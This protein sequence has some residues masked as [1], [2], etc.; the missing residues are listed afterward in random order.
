M[1]LT[2]YEAIER[3]NADPQ[4]WEHVT[5]ESAHS[6]PVPIVRPDGIAL[7]FFWYPVGG[8][9]MNRFVVAPTWRTEISLVAPDQIRFAPVQPW[10]LGLDVEPK[11]QL[12]KPT[13]GGSIPTVEMKALRAEL[14]QLIDEI[15]QFYL[16]PHPELSE[17]EKEHARRFHAL[18]HRM[19]IVLLLPAY[20]SL[21]PD[22]FT[23]LDQI[24]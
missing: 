20:R 17:V 9:A 1:P 5:R 18:F 15:I 14:Y 22:F 12:G 21:N 23:W 13:I 6:L 8:P 24:V 2:T 19:A 10:E 4:R 16:K 3:L 7:A 11:T